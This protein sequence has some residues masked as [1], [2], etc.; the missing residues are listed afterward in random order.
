MHHIPSKG[1]KIQ[2]LVDFNPT[3]RKPVSIALTQAHQAG[4]YVYQET[5]QFKT[6]AKHTDPLTSLRPKPVGLGDVS[7]GW[8]VCRTVVLPLNISSNDERSTE[9]EHVSP[10]WTV[11][12]GTKESKTSLTLPCKWGTELWY[13]Q[14]TVSEAEGPSL[15]PDSLLLSEPER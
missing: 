6:W 9:E 4:H 2:M 14:T 13:P 15:Q 7:S 12:A 11:R 3:L 10:P 8:D 5:L 1:L